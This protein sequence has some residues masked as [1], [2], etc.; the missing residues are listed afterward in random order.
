MGAPPHED[1]SAQGRREKEKGKE[2]DEKMWRERK[3]GVEGEKEVKKERRAEGEREREKERW[4][5][6]NLE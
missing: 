6:W 3:D 1:Y 5:G 2:R 4:E